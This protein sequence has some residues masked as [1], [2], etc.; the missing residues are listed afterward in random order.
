MTLYSYKSQYPKPLP[1]RITLS[2]G[3]TRTD[4]SSFTVQEIEDAGYTV[5]LDKPIVNPWQNLNWTGASWAVSDKPA[6]QLK[7]EKEHQI[8]ALREQLI[9]SQKMVVLS[10]GQTI[11]IDVRQ[12]KPD[13]QNLTNIV[14]KASLKVMRNETGTITFMAADNQPYTLTPE[15]A[16]EMGESVFAQI[17]NEYAQSWVKKAQLEALT[18]AQEVY[19][20]D[21]R[22]NI[23]EEVEEANTAPIDEV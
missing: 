17:E 7:A 8:N 21:I 10:T 15:E 18:T 9:Y 1:H 16:I 23:V 19:E 14:Q 4:P 11:P 2:D 12:G 13:I 5:A 20:F 6:D 22:W 3:R